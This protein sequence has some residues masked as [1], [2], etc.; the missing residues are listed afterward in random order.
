MTHTHTQTH[1][2][3]HDMYNDVSASLLAKGMQLW[4]LRSDQ[5]TEV[6]RVCVC[7]C[8]CVCARHVPSFSALALLQGSS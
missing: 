2:H 1:T 8:V 6:T 3:T 5:R 7:V 4:K